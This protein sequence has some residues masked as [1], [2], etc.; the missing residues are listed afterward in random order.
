LFIW[1]AMYAWD[2]ALEFLY[3]HIIDMVRP[4]LLFS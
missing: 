3:R 4:T 1:H 2:E